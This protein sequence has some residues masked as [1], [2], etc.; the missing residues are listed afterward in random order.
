MLKNRSEVLKL[1]FSAFFA[2][3]GYQAAVASFPLIFVIYFGA[4]IYL[5]GLAEAINYGGGTLMSFLGGKLSDKYGR[6]K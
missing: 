1:S 4:P 2:D 5:Y 6:K 3:L